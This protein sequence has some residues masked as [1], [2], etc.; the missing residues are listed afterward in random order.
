MLSILVLTVLSVG[1]V[2]TARTEVFSSYNY[3]LDTQATYV[4]DAGLQTAVNWFK[5]SYSPANAS[6]YNLSVSPVRTVSNNKPVKLEAGSGANYPDSTILTS[7]QTN[8]ANQTLNVPTSPPLSATITV[9]A[10]LDSARMVNVLGQGPTLLERWTVTSRGQAASGVAEASAVIT[11]FTQ[12]GLPTYAA[13][14]CGTGPASLTIGDKSGPVIGLTDSYDSGVAPYT[15]AT[16]GSQGNV[17]T[18]GQ[19][20]QDG[21]IVNGSA[22]YASITG[23][24]TI[25]GTSTT[26][27]SA[28]DC[29]KIPLPPTVVGSPGANQ[30]FGGGSPTLSPGSYGNVLCSSACNLTLNPGTYNLNSLEVDSGSFIHISGPTIINIVGTDPVSKALILGSDSV[31]NL[32]PPANLQILVSRTEPIVADSGTSASYVLIAP[33]SA[34]VNDSNTSTYGL[35]IAKT[36]TL[37]S[38]AQIHYDLALSRLRFVYQISD[39]KLVTW[40]RAAF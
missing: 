7:F 20:V 26:V 28:V 22:S 32:L 15:A 10:S 34:V 37:D 11:R 36:L 4:A 16:A 12:G 27:A 1:I 25:T 23:A 40:Q 29:S 6:A 8:L 3:R 13:V 14:A 38:G 5:N 17:A 31:V 9:K 24:G 18:N 21:G 39:P 33:N 35:I 19:Y 30:T 2:F